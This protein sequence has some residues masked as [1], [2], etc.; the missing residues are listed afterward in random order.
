M[1]A[2]KGALECFPLLPEDK[3]VDVVVMA[4]S[5]LTSTLAVHIKDGQGR[6]QVPDRVRQLLFHKGLLHPLLLLL[7]LS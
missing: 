4:V 7:L 3:V 1:T 5:I 2:R 6:R